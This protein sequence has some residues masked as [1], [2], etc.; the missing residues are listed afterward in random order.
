MDLKDKGSNGEKL[1]AKEQIEY[2][3]NKG[4]TFNYIDET[5]ALKFLKHNTYYYK[6]TSFRKN[7]NKNNKK[8]INLDYG[9]LNDLATID[10]YLRYL[11]MKL[12]LDLE[13]SL[14]T[15]LVSMITEYNVEDGY[16]IVTEFDDY[17][18]EKF[19]N[20]NPTFPEYKYQKLSKKIMKRSKYKDGY[21]YDLYLK[22]GTNPSIWVLI[23]LM[24]YGELVRFIEFYYTNKDY[25]KKSLEDAYIL[26]K[27]TKNFRDAAAHSRPLILNVTKNNN[28]SPNE[29]VTTFA[30]AANIDKASRGKHFS[31]MKIHDF[32][33]ILI[34]HMKYISSI[35]M[36]KD[37][38][39][40]MEK[41]INRC[42]K[43]EEI[44]K[45]CI[46]LKEVFGIFSKIIDSYN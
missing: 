38:K 11:S 26:L 42:K 5:D 46:E 39:L 22:R 41:L 18:K 31:N 2:M 35:E 12:T 20:D 6:V 44:Y 29:L 1:N 21:S 30:K 3:K 4:I 25:E 23:E 13:H 37:R 14:K 32:S 43:R 15:L 8:Y 19:L 36:K 24:S 40:E 16:S 27:Y 10:M 33:C 34:L 9:H 45:D 7:F 17:C 28:F